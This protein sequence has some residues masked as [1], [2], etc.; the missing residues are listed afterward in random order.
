[1]IL[2]PVKERVLGGPLNTFHSDD[3]IASIAHGLIHR[4][5]PRER[6]THAAH[7]A[8]ALWFLCH[9]SF[10]DALRFIRDSIRSYNE[11]SGVANTETSG[12][13]ETITEASL[14][15]AAHFRYIGRDAPLHAVCNELLAS[16]FGKS[17]WILRHWTKERLFTPDARKRWVDPDLS[18][19]PF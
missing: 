17:D 2:P 4:T 15:A 10:E 19:L 16:P 12:Y 9:Y 18:A 6:W 11:A 7:F 8:A 13:H 14:R 5:L 1:M 3:E